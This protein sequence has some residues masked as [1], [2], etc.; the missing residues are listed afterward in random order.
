MPGCASFNALKSPIIIPRTSAN[1]KSRVRFLQRL[2]PAADAICHSDHMISR[3]EA[4]DRLARLQVMITVF[5]PENLDRLRESVG[6]NLFVRAKGVTRSLDD[7]SGC[8]HVGEMRCAQL[9]R[10]ADR[11]EWVAQTQ[12]SGYPARGV[13][14]VGYHAGDAA[15]QRFS[16]NDERA[17]GIK[18][19]DRS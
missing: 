8:L 1:R 5:N 6:R 3:G 13:E 2:G 10:F 16:A 19:I 7:E 15:P 4:G 17:R 14:L 9:I 11:V 18:C 12:Q